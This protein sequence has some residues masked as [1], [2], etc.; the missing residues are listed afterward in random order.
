[1]PLA[2]LSCTF[3][4]APG[5]N[6]EDSG[7]LDTVTAGFVPALPWSVGAFGLTATAT[8]TFCSL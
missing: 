5:A 4:V 2:S 1:M 6:C 7:K 8:L 3:T